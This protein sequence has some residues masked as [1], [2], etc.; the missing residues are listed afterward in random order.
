MRA[1]HLLLLLLLLLAL[2]APSRVLAHG[3]TSH[4]GDMAVDNRIAIGRAALTITQVH[5]CAGKMAADLWAATDTDADGRISEP[6]W[7]R[8]IEDSRT[9]YQQWCRLE[10][11]WKT[12]LPAQ[13]DVKLASFPRTRPATFTGAN[14]LVL[15]HVARY[16]TPDAGPVRNVGLNVTSLN[17]RVIRTR[18]HCEP[19]MKVE[20]ASSGTL[21]G[22]GSDVT[23]I[24][25]QDG[26]PDQIALVVREDAAAASQAPRGLA[27]L[28]S[29]HAAVLG[30]GLLLLLTGFW[31]LI[32]SSVAYGRAAAL[33]APA[34][35][36]PIA[37]GFVLIAGG[38]LL[39]LRAL[40]HGGVLKLIR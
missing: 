1:G 6:E 36:L 19:G 12:V 5:T 13:V 16:A 14:T 34:S 23:G 29:V 10:V 28:A 31:H 33:E 26:L 3:G 8:G 17:A 40:V 7:A 27:T 2:G 25:Q 21:E 20:S 35:V 18:V 30:A 38:S 4:S 15:E 11:D 32:A 9:V 24:L 22:G 39:I 37:F